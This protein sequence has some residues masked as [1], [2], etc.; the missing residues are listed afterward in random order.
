MTSD[1]GEI[2]GEI[3]KNLI[4]TL[5]NNDDK[6]AIVKRLE[7]DEKTK[8]NRFLRQDREGESGRVE[9]GLQES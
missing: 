7:N 9:R 4:A 5:K 2:D 6:K 3:K 1:V 8:R